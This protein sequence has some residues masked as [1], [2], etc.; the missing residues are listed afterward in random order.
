MFKFGLDNIKYR[1]TQ[2]HNE[3]D[4]IIEEKKAY[5]IKFSKNLIKESK[6]Q[7]FKTNYSDFNLEFITFDDFLQFLLEKM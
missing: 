6:Y 7:L 2:Q 5:E 1:R 4:F 3:V